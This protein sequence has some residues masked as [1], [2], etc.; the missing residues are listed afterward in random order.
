MGRSTPSA[1]ARRS[2][3]CH[4]FDVDWLSALDFSQA[5]ANVQTDIR[6]DWY[7]DPWDWRELE[8]LVDGHIEEYALPRLNA[9]GVKRTATL[10]VPKEN[11]AIRPAV[12]MDPLDRLLYQGL[13]DTLSVRL[14]GAIPV[15]AYGW[16]L[17]PTKPARGRWVPNDEQ[18]DAFRDHLQRLADYDFAALTTDVVSF[19]ASIPEEPLSEQIV[20]LGGNRPAERLVDMIRAW[21]RTT[22]RGL[23]QRSAASAAIAHIY[24]RPLDDVLGRFSAMPSRG[25]VWVPEG[26][27]LRWMDD[28]WVF[29]RRQSP[30]REAQIALQ[31]AMRDLGLE[32]NI[33]KTRVL[34]GD[35]MAEAVYALEHSA[36]DAALNEDDPI[37]NRWTTSSAASLP[38]P[39]SPSGRRFGS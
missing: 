28:I 13:V 6:G 23:P 33:G 25:A 18:W 11:F 19:F 16:R 8:W 27:A 29:A 5:L 15:W 31:A 37:L 39:R 4:Y 22:G 36:V 24:L 20:T 34:Y 38:H 30:L 9:A 17:S 3:T 26:R 10:D 1:R 12:V 7:R 21:Y 32:M 35:D 14:I 2:G